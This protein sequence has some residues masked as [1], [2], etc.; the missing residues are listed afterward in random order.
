MEQ[1]SFQYEKVGVRE[2]Q[3]AGACQHKVLRTVLRQM[4]LCWVQLESG[5]HVFGQWYSWIMMKSWVFACDVR[6]EEAEFEVQ[7]TI[8]RAELAAFPCLL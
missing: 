6:L 4:A 2:A 3:K 1:V 5:E 7:R 8:Q